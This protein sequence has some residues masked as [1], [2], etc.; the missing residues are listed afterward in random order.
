MPVVCVYKISKAQETFGAEKKRILEEYLQS[1]SGEE[2]NFL[3]GLPV[4]HKKR[5][6]KVVPLQRRHRKI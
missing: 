3:Q 2:A 4:T 1:I 6:A 5:S